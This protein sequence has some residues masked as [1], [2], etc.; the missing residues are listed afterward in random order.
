MISDDSGHLYLVG[1]TEN[2][3]LPGVTGNFQATLPNSNGSGFL[4]KFD[5]NKAPASSLVY[6]TYLGGSA[7]VSAAQA[8]AIDASGNAY[9]TGTTAATIFRI[10]WLSVPQPATLPL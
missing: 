5:T 9:V 10:A 7:D 4:A 3:C 6:S 2:P 8:V 1:S